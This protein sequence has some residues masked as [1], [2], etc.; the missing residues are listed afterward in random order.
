M[1]EPQAAGDEAAAASQDD[2]SEDSADGVEELDPTAVVKDSSSDDGDDA[3]LGRGAHPVHLGE[4]GGAGHQLVGQHHGERFVAD[5]LMALDV[6]Q[7]CGAGA[8]ER[9]ADRVNGLRC[10]PATFIR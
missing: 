4:H 2:A 8:H 10:A 7:L 1:P 3:A 6:D 9:S 5:R